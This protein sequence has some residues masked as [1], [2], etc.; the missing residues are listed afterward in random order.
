VPLAQM[1][2]GVSPEHS[3]WAQRNKSDELSHEPDFKNI[4]RFSAAF[5][6]SWENRRCRCIVHTADDAVSQ[7]P[8]ALA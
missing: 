6:N 7:A 1:H 8:S 4:Y 5:A 2:S 3:E